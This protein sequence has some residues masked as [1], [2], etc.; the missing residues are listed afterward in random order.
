MFKMRVRKLEENIKGCPSGDF[1]SRGRE[2]FPLL[3]GI[4]LQEQLSKCVFV[5]CV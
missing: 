5:L 4:A 3:N 1:P 2:L